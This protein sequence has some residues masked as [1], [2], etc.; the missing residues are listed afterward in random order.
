VNTVNPTLKATF[1]AVTALAFGSSGFE[2]YIKLDFSK[3][4]TGGFI[5]GEANALDVQA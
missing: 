1:K 4:H 5:T 3:A 2:S